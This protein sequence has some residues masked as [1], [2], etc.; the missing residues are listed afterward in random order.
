MITFSHKVDF[1]ITTNFLKK[2]KRNKITVDL[3]KYGRMGVEA[4]SNATPTDTGLTAKSRKYEIIQG[5]GSVTIRYYNTNVQ[6]GIPIAV[7]LQ[8][9]HATKNGGW[10]E[11]Q[12]YINPAIQPIFD[13][14]VKEAWGEVSHS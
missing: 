13:S 4:L 12:D 11:G 10:V 14:I 5:D 8:Y 3:D 7:I 6:N 2:L 1:S 9:G